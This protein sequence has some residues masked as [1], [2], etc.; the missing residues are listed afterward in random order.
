MVTRQELEEKYE[1]LYFMADKLF[2]DCKICNI[3]VEDGEITCRGGHSCC[4]GDSGMIVPCEYLGADGC[5]I[6]CLMCKVYICHRAA[7]RYPDVKR[8]LNRIAKIAKA[9]G[10]LF[11]YEDKAVTIDRL[12]RWHN[13]EAI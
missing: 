9:H 1:R 11:Y 10:F 12:M 5:T 8:N 3:E 7:V 13:K 6:V 4:G 2:Q